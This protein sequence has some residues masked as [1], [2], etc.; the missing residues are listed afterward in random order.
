[1]GKQK[2]KNIAC[3][4]HVVGIFPEVIANLPKEDPDAIGPVA[5]HLSSSSEGFQALPPRLS[6]MV[7]PLT[8]TSNEPDQAQF[9]EGIAETLTTD[10]SRIRRA[11]VIA[12]STAK[13]Y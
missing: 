13:V 7:L 3:P 1:L 10:L 4:V 2:L 12:P 11:F 6:P 5:P 9:A 8:S